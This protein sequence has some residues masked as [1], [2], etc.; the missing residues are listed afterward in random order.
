MSCQSSAG[1]PWP[2][3]GLT[4]LPHSL[5]GLGRNIILTTMPAGAKLIAGNKPV[6]FL[7]AQQLQ[8]LQQQGQAT[9]V[10]PSALA[11][12]RLLPSP[13]AHPH[14]G[15]LAICPPASLSVHRCASRQSP[16][17][18][19]SREQPPVPLRPSPP[20][21][22]PRPR[23]LSRHPSSSDSQGG[24]HSAAGRHASWPSGWEGRSTVAA[25]PHSARLG[26]YLRKAS[27]GTPAAL[28]GEWAVPGVLGPRALS[29]LV[30]EKCF[31]WGCV[32]SPWSHEPS[33]PERR[34][35]GRANVTGMWMVSETRSVQ[36]LCLPWPCL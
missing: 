20:S 4:P 10:R 22:S 21:S 16:H 27:S 19:S 29:C 6:S 15:P 24:R 8:Q 2:G 25:S 35:W 12:L 11:G 30:R 28:R 3:P 5:G 23:L 13:R 9:Q 1:V 26:G 32:N 33:S 7:T 17:P 14:C 36:G 31:W 34:H 18:T